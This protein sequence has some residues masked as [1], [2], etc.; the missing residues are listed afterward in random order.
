[1]NF[2]SCYEVGC[3]T[4]SEVF[5]ARNTHIE[6]RPGRRFP[7]VTT[8]CYVRLVRLAIIRKADLRPHWI[9]AQNSP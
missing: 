4:V 7:A 2:A 3:E 8:K 9:D 1:M 6:D 5:S